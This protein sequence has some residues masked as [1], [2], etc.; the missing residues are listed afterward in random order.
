MELVLYDS[1]KKVYL[2]KPIPENPPVTTSDENKAWRISEQEIEHAWHIA[3]K[4]AWLG[5]GFFYV[6]GI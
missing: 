3:Y 4:S 1:Q 6:H 5:I 2:A